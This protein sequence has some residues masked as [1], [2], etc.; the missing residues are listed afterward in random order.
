MPRDCQES[1]SDEHLK[2]GLRF[3]ES[4]E[5]EVKIPSDLTREHVLQA[6]SS[7]DAG[8]HHKWGKS[9][10]FDLVHD[11]KHYSPKAVLG[12]AICNLRK[13]DQYAC[14]FSGGEETNSVLQKLG[15]TIVEKNPYDER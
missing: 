14:D 5:V 7:L 9:R 13:L 2:I 4:G 11:G 10:K 6:L 8:I 15:F 1:R 12:L 3:N